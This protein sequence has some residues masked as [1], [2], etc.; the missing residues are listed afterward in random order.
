MA[1]GLLALARREWI[2]GKPVGSFGASR[3]ARIGSAL[4]LGR[5]IAAFSVTSEEPVRDPS[6]VAARLI[7][8][9]GHRVQETFEKFRAMVTL[10][11]ADSRMKDYY[12]I[13]RLAATSRS[14]GRLCT[15]PWKKRF[16]TAVWCFRM[17]FQS[18]C[19]QRVRT[20][21]GQGKAVAR[22][23]EPI[24]CVAC[25]H[26]RGESSSELRHA[27]D[28]RPGFDLASWVPEFRTSR[29]RRG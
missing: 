26:R 22:I 12:D 2:P 17:R 10:A 25:V 20:V 6:A 11:G 18:G 8:S 3:V 19:D 23:R 27:G 13:D 14:M 5:R 29:W 7:A 16:S 4:E 28:H 21:A 15:P 24:R 1:D 9:Y